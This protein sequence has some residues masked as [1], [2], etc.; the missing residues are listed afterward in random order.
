RLYFSGLS[1]RGVFAAFM[2]AQGANLAL[3]LRISLRIHHQEKEQTSPLGY[4]H[5]I[6]IRYYVG[7]GRPFCLP[8][9]FLD[10]PL[11][12]R[13][14]SRGVVDGCQ[15]VMARPGRERVTSISFL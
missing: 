9:L 7:S 14:A 12:D 15:L 3:Q 8:A 2:S 5:A 13:T 6:G 11:P 1:S 10:G 4:P